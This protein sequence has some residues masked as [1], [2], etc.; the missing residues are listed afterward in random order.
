MPR[1]AL[2]VTYSLELGGTQRATVFLAET[3]ARAGWRVDVFLCADRPRHFTLPPA[4]AVIEGWRAKGRANGLGLAGRSVAQALALRS[5][6][7]AHR[8]D[9]IVG[10]GNT[11]SLLALAA[12][13][14]LGLPVVVSDRVAPSQDGME[15]GLWRV[16]VRLLYPRA[17]RLV[18]ITQGIATERAW[19]PEGKVVVIP[20]AVQV[21][22]QAGPHDPRLVPAGSP[23]LI[24]LG[25]LHPQKGFDLLLEAF[26][27][28]APQ[29]PAWHLT[30]LGE[31]PERAA[32]ERLVARFG[33]DG[34][35]Q[36]PGAVRSPAPPLRAAAEAGGVFAFPSRYEGFPNALIEA[37]ACGL[38]VVAADCPHGPR[39]ILEGGKHGLLVPPEN[40]E[41]LAEALARLMADP[42]LRADHA[43]RARARAAD[44]APER[45]AP[46]WLNLLEEVMREHH[47]AD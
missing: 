4:I 29:F 11:P 41:A 12:S 33:L 19:L 25:R 46:L 16:A 28:L 34:R 27:R 32:L 43:A 18:A 40:P 21:D 22:G 14:G 6:L 37:M 31:G 42:A 36:L 7:R 3:L 10:L 15:R 5:V 26:A 2:L 39:E 9:V 38:P 44:F 20:N 47:I 13:R 17:A 24:A 8:P 30:I 1:R 35:V 23:H 45:I